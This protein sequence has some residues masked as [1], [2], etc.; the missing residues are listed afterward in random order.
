MFDSEL[1]ELCIGHA[2][3][4]IKHTQRTVPGDASSLNIQYGG[5]YYV[6]NR[7]DR[8][9]LKRELVSFVFQLNTQPSSWGRDNGPPAAGVWLTRIILNTE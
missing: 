6:V 5:S 3:N 2:V 7:G 4:L 9:A 1:S 8:H